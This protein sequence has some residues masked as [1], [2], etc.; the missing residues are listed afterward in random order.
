M[1]TSGETT[2]A[3]RDYLPLI[4]VVVGGVLAVAGGFLSN[5]FLEWRRHSMESKKLAY[6]FKGEI[7]ALVSIAETR[8]YVNHIQDI[9]TTMEQPARPILVDVPVRREYFNVFR[10]NVN[11][12]GA[13]R[14]PLPELVARFYVQANSILE[15]FDSYRDSPRITAGVDFLIGSN[16]E[17]LA[18]MK[19]TFALG[20]EIVGKIDELYS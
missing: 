16:K 12:I 11:N 7:Q 10:G 17:L 19:S 1:G 8:G 2:I 9:I 14:N 6:A 18:L 4:G 5:F 3:L 13:L 15:D 20:W